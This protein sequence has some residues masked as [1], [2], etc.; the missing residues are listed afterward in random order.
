EEADR[1]ADAGRDRLGLVQAW[2]HYGEFHAISFVTPGDRLRCF[3]LI[4]SV[5]RCGP[6]SVH[7]ACRGRVM[8]AALVKGTRIVLPTCNRKTLTATAAGGRLGRQAY[9]HGGPGTRGRVCR[10]PELAVPPDRGPDTGEVRQWGANRR[11]APRSA[12]R[13]GAS[14][15][16]AP[17]EAATPRG[18]V[19]RRAGPG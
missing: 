5:P 4:F 8:M 9:G 7:D 11:R 17:R 1:L 12:R 19:P 15:G 3:P 16:T 10:A 13:R 18:T 14:R 6:S 2:H